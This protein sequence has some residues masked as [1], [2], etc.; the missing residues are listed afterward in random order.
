MAFVCAA[1][2]YASAEHWPHSAPDAERRQVL[3]RGLAAEPADM[4][5]TGV[6]WYEA[7]AYA[8][9][10]GKRLPSLLE[11]EYAVRGGHAYR[12]FSC[13]VEGQPLDASGFNVD[14]DI[15]GGRAPWPV[16]AGAD[17]TPAGV[18]AGIRNL[19]S[20]VA[21][22]TGEVDADGRAAAA[23]GSYRSLGSVFDFD[24]VAWRAADRGYAGVGLRCAADAAAVDAARAGS[25]RLVLR[26][27]GRQ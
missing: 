13:A 8:H 23:G 25:G 16:M 9:W 7:A 21:E 4:P 24:T 14:L 10:A 17:C 19:S 3:A 20:N 27:Q 12:P 26:G 22:W 5:V 11:W 6:T 18:G 1:D 15:R 2:G